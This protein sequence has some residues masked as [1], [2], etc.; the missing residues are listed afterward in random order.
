M[1]RFSAVCVTAL[2][3]VALDARAQT[4]K[5][6]APAATPEAIFKTLGVR[7]GQT[8]C[9]IG[10]GTGDVS[11]AAARIV[12]PTGRI[13]TSELGESRIKVLQER[14]TASGLTHITVVT[15]EATRTGFTDAACDAVFLKDVYH[16][17]TDPAAMNRSIAAALKPGARLLV[18]DFTP[19]PGQEATTPADRGKDGMHGIGVE[20]LTRELNA[21]GFEVVSSE[22]PA[23]GIDRWF[24]VLARQRPR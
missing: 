14:V 21:A 20:S 19:P 18:I 8:I 10:A 23:G 24:W 7:E 11:I 6:A 12:G 16:H 1:R 13:Y 15:G 22:G 9:E 17:F 5:P 3:L 4:Q 2:V